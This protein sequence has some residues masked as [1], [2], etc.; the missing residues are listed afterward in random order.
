[1]AAAFFLPEP[2]HREGFELVLTISTFLFAIIAGFFIS[3]LNSRFDAIRTIIGE[4][5]GEF[6]TLYKLAQLMSPRFSK[7]IKSILNDFYIVAYDFALSDYDKTY[8]ESKIYYMKFWQELKKLKKSERIEPFHEKCVDIIVASEKRRNVT[9]ALAAER[10][11]LGQWAVLIILSVIIIFCIY[12]LKTEE[13]Y[14]R[15]LA[16]LLSTVLMLVLL[17]MRDLQNLVLGQTEL[18]EESGQE[19]FEDIGELRYY[20]SRHLKTGLSSVPP[21][22]KKFRLGLHE[23]GAKEFKIKI[24]TR[25]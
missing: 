15:F 5:D 8:K 14:S 2:Q 24:I 22:I 21:H 6:L 23:P 3:R 17:L 19:M 9:S 4:G 10:L 20:Q 1:M 13:L 16:I 18:L 11:T 7:R 12:S 25:E